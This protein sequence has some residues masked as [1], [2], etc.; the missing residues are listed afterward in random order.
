MLTAIIVTI[1]LIIIYKIIGNNYK[2]RINIMNIGLNSLRENGYAIL[3]IKPTLLVGTLKTENY[4]TNISTVSLA[5]MLD[6]HETIIMSTAN[7]NSLI[8]SLDRTNEISDDRLMELVSE[9]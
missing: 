4:K 8:L 3:A 1:I 9:N 7:E 2:K 5:F 6:G